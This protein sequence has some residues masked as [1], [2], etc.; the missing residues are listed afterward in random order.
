VKKVKKTHLP[1]PDCGSSDALTVYDNGSHCFACGTT[2]LNDKEFM[3]EVVKESNFSVIGTHRPNTF[4]N[5]SAATA[6]HYN[7]TGDD[8]GNTYFNYANDKG[9]LVASKKRTK[10]KEFIISGNWSATEPLFGQHLFT[11]GGKYVTI[12]EGEWDAASSYQ[13]T[14]SKWANVSVKGGAGNALKDCR[15]AYEWLNSFD[16]IIIAFD[17]DEP[18][19]KAAKQVAEL[20]GIKAKIVKHK[21]GYKDAS[22]YLTHNDSK[23]YIDA[24]W[25]AEQFTPDGIINGSNLFDEVMAPIEKSPAL[26]P[27]EGLNKLTYGIRNVELVTI[28]AGSGLG[29]S[30]V[31]RE[32]VWHLLNK[33]A[34]NIG[35]FFLEEGRRRTGLGLMSM[36]ANKPLHLPTTEV[37]DDEKREAFDSTLGTGRIW[38]HDHF[39]STDIDNI[40]SRVRYMAKALDCRYIFLDH[41]TI[42]VS[43]QQNPDERKALDEV[44]TKLRMLVQETGISLFVVSHLKR[45][46]G[47]GHEEGAATSL[48]QLR[49]S[50]AIAQLSDMVIGLERNGQAEDETVRNTTKVRVLK[51]RFAGIT[52]P[53]SELLYNHAT[54]RINELEEETL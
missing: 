31:L 16:N 47:K 37:T 42:V 30:Q 6:E 21:K 8:A 20:F 7:I 33:T 23:E 1:C 9:E 43:N 24:W 26:Y 2:T 34:D 32:I 46:E 53:A 11:P 35:M 3:T 51:N 15:K 25:A 29:K 18:G 4:R 49:G 38:L 40:V 36:A 28:T 10:D 48:A 44:M 19:Q 41:I 5:I 17:A 52:G 22:D 13:M 27:W 50:G 12:L 54:G 14:G 39:G 45:P